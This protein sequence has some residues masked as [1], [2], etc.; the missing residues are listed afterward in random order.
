MTQATSQAAPWPT[1]DIVAFS[2]VGIVV[3]SISEFQSTWGSLMGIDDWLVRDVPQPAGRLQLFGET[4]DEPS[5]NLIAFA[6]VKGLSIELIEPHGGP[7]ASG[8]W[9]EEHGPGINHLGVWVRDL[10]GALEQLAEVTQVTYSAASL[11]SNLADRPATAVIEDSSKWRPP[12]WA[13]LEPWSGS[14][15]WQL[16]LLDVE[17]EGA[18]REYYGDYAFYPGD[19]PGTDR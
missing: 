4:V 1:I 12:F 13:Y 9:L 18:Y 11:V 15:G 17:F 3:P 6:K 8:R 19:L 16:E 5:A 14:T 7:T 2:H 10:S